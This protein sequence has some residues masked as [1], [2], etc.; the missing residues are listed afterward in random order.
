M[1]VKGLLQTTK[2]C[3]SDL[4]LTQ[5]QDANT[6]LQL[7]VDTEDKEL[8]YTAPT[9]ICVDNAGIKTPYVVR[10]KVV[11]DSETAA[12]VSEVPEYSVDGATWTTTTPTGTIAIGSCDPIVVP[13]IV[14]PRNQILETANDTWTAASAD[15]P[16]KLR[17]VSLAITAIGDP[18]NDGL[19]ITDTQGNVSLYRDLYMGWSWSIDVPADSYLGDIQFKVLGATEASVSWTEEV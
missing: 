12:V 4:A 10:Q 14:N 17:S 13:K 7:L 1:P 16:L 5:L 9:A 15:N 6:K 11:Y 18:I 19:E 3:N 8:T 2:D